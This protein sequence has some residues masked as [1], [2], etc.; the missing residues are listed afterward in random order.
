MQEFSPK[1]LIRK[2]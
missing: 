2:I 1:T